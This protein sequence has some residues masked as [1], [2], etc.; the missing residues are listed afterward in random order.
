[1]D[2]AVRPARRQDAPAIAALI[3]GLGLFR[4]LAGEE[5]ASTQ[6]RVLRHL[7]LCLADDSHTVLVATDPC[8]AIV[9]YA[10]VH[11]LPYL[12]LTGPEGY[13]S[14]L[15]VAESHR[16]QGIGS[17]L[18]GAVVSEAR[19]RGCARLML[20]AVKTRESYRR[21]FYRKQGWVERE[22]MANFVYE[23]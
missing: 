1:M 21:G 8:Q 15:F 17:A 14:E 3:R 16:G 20:E 4:R 2:F 10:G 22:D 5:P 19:R 9:G 23:L 13:L 6:A 11:W 7:D 12:F 18:L